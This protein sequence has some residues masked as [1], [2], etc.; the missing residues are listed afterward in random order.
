MKRR[1]G[2]PVPSTIGPK[3]PGYATQRAM[4]RWLIDEHERD[5]FSYQ[6]QQ[7]YSFVHEYYYISMDLVDSVGDFSKPLYCGVKGQ[8]GKTPAQ[9]VR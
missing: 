9:Q 3:D 1:K 4:S 6:Q 8:S 2:R 7:V 5:P